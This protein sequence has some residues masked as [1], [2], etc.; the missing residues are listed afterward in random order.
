[1]C[2]S[3][4]KVLQPHRVGSEERGR[5]R[6]FNAYAFRARGCGQL[7]DASDLAE[8]PTASTITSIHLKGIPKPEVRI[9]REMGPLRK[10]PASLG[11]PRA[12]G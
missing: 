2:M 4:D 6:A 10:G 9:R 5:G 7:K 1:M 12:S 11:E 3:K 8:A